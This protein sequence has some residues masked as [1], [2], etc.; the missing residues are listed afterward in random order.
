MEN[1][2]SVIRNRRSP[3][4]TG[5]EILEATGGIL[6]GGSA[7][8]IF[9]GIST[10][11]RDISEGN[12]F[13]PLKGERF[14][15]HNFLDV[16]VRAGA[17][18][19]IVRG[20][21]AN[22]E[23]FKDI[24]VIRVDDTL[25]AL[26]CIAHFWRKKFHIPIVAI[27]GSSGKT[28]TK[29]MSAHIAGL[30]KKVAKTEGNFNNLIGLPLTIFQINDQ[31][32]VAILEMGTNT[33]GEIGKL[34]RIAAPDIGL[35]TNIGPAHLE[36][37][38]S[39]DAIREEKGELFQYMPA[40]SIAIVNRD[41]EE[42][43]ILGDRWRGKRITFGMKMDADVSAENIR[44]RGDRGVSFT[45]NMAGTSREVT[46]ATVGLHNIYNALAAAAS[47]RALG[48]EPHTIYRGLATFKSISGRMEIHRLRNGAF[49]IDDTYNANPV[50]V[51]EA[52]KTLND[53]KG[54]HEST[55]IMADML[56]LDERVE[57]MHRAVGSFMAET[58]VGTVF[59][60]GSFSR[61]TAEGAIR[62][63]IP[64]KRIFF[65]ETTA[66]IVAYLRASLN[67]GDWVLVKGSRKMKMEE[68]SREIIRTFGLMEN[69][70][71]LT[72]GS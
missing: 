64:D 27:T 18:G 70:Q 59:L 5:S 33:P 34:T 38:G 45:L 67:K 65:P 26:G 52:L 61:A 2:K 55:V 53:L 8:R 20:E 32:E 36:G 69:N 63:G 25:N 72:T 7:E 13:I 28:T 71:E 10:D 24:T 68:I 35:I 9:Q 50:S 43:G 44:T 29:E 40:G 4:I 12:F 42:V 14:N 37:F 66:E 11:S 49:L 62:G 48:L 58:G 54:N 23:G 56:E 31:H 6:I 41:D 19:F 22:N 16:A 17:T 46:M 60:R 30:T 47:C 51:R 1:N 3:V 15:G 39:I 57:E 21:S